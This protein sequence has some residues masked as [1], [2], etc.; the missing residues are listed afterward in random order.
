MSIKSK[1]EPAIRVK[2]RGRTTKVRYSRYGQMFMWNF[3]GNRFHVDD[4]SLAEYQAVY[5]QI[6]RHA[7]KHRLKNARRVRRNFWLYMKR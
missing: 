3:I 1:S 6:R 5:R 4:L 2:L 7:A